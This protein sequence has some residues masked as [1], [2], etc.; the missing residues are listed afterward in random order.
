LIDRDL[1]N[2]IAVPAWNCAD[3]IDELV[4]RLNALSMDL[5]IFVVDDASTDDTLA[6]AQAYE[7][8]IA[9]RNQTNRGY[10][11]TSKRLYEMAHE[12]GVDLVINVHGDLG[13]NPEDILPIIEGFRATEADFVFG[14]RLVYIVEQL[15]THGHRLFLDPELRGR[16]PLVRLFGHF[17][18]TFVQNRLFGQR[19]K[20]YHEGMRGSSAATVRWILEQDLPDWYDF[21]T[22]LLVRGASAGFHI[23]EVPVP[24]RYHTQAKSSAPPFRYGWKV[25]IGSIRNAPRY[26]RMRRRVGK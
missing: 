10:G 8:V 3:T 24:P 12:A 14:S 15:K 18:L 1:H 22:T 13:H 4:Q 20:S 16:M 23:E 6:K 25:L 26:R 21:D 19:L 7:N 11:G 5:T 9:V 2:G 17:G